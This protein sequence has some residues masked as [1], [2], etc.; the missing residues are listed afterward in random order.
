MSTGV[1]PGEKFDSFIM[2]TISARA[3]KLDEFY[4]AVE[5]AIISGDF[6]LTEEDKKPVSSSNKQ[7]KWRRTVRNRLGS[8]WKDRLAFNPEAV[9][10]YV[11]HRRAMCINL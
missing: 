2:E 6:T 9:P 11:V 8:Y 4:D 7:K 10:R 3:T 5:S 1:T